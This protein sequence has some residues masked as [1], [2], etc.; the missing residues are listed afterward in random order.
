[1]EQKGVENEVCSRLIGVETLPGNG[2]GPN[3]E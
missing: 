3:P 1:M 2:W